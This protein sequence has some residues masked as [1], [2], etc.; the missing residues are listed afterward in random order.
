VGQPCIQAKKSVLT[1]NGIRIDVVSALATPFDKGVHEWGM[2]LVIQLFELCRGLHRWEN[3]SRTYP[4][5]ILARALIVDLLPFHDSKLCMP[6]FYY[7]LLGLLAQIYARIVRRSESPD[8]A[9]IQ[10]ECLSRFM[11]FLENWRQILDGPNISIPG[12]EHISEL[13]DAFVTAGYESD[14]QDDATCEALF[15]MEGRDYRSTLTFVRTGRCLFRTKR[16]CLGF[17]WNS[18]QIGDEVWL[19]ESAMIPFILRREPDAKSHNIVGEAYIQGIMHGE[20]FDLFSI[21][22]QFESIRIK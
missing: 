8:N 17:S 12:Y 16:G 20:V 15:P 4:L 5:E 13:G 2:E 10:S 9:Q 1:L 6:A 3:E 22:R 21:S 14:F 11:T 7:F 18:A 19:L